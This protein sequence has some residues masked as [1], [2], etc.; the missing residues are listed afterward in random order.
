M[1]S[2]P[3]ST[4][5]VSTGDL[6]VIAPQ[7][8]RVRIRRLLRLISAD[9]GSHGNRRVGGGW[10]PPEP[11]MA[12]DSYRIPELRWEGKSANPPPGGFFVSP[13]PPDP[14]SR[15]KTTEAGTTMTGIWALAS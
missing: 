5:R 3:A 1:P 7:S 13:K 9:Y 15:T 4:V 14:T 2:S 11:P 10:S 12:N 6:C 8:H